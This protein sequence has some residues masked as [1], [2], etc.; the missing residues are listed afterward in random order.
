[1]SVIVRSESGVLFEM[2][3]PVG[4][5]AKER[6]DESI[7]TGRLTI[8]NTPVKWVETTEG[9]KRLVDVEAAEAPVV[10]ARA[11]EGAGPVDAEPDAP[12][13]RGRKPAA[14][15]ADVDD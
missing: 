1:V 13:A 8:V 6:F 7:A 14:P 3:V 11:P 12:K 2:D 9:A 10:P 4:A 5:L 15:A